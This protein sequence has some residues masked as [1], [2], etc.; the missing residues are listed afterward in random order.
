MANIENIIGSDFTGGTAPSNDTLTLLNHVS[1][2]SIN[3]GDGNNTLNLAAGANS[4]DSLV[5]VNTVHGSASNDV[6]TVAQPS[7]TTTFDMGAGNDIVNFAGQAFGATVVDA[8]T[9]NGSAGS[10]FITIANTS[11]STTVTGGLGADSLV[12]SA[13]VDH[14]NFTA[15]AESQTGNGDTIVNFNAA[16]DTF[17]FTGITGFT[18]PIQFIGTAAFDGSGSEAHIDTAG[19]DANLQIDVNGDGVMDSHDIEIHLAS[20]VGTLHN[21]NFILS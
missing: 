13:G 19:P 14:F 17:T 5:G 9:V 10:D 20:Y 8:E 18:G 7:F 1:G 12:A 16:N 15:A 21:S 4:L 3:L 6:L 2:V 11:G